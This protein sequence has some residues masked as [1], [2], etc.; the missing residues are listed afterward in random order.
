ML[1]ENH[2]AQAST[3]RD[4]LASADPECDTYWASSTAAA[5]RSPTPE[6]RSPRHRRGGASPRAELGL[7]CLVF[8]SKAED[9]E[10]GLSEFIE[11]E[12]SAYATGV[13]PRYFDTPS[14]WP[15]RL[16]PASPP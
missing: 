8:L 14:R 7:R 1:T 11:R 12:V 13:W 16:P 2:I 4:L 10:P 6:R 5:A 15:G 9:R 3:V